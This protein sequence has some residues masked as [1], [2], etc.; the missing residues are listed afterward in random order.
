M[1]SQFIV[2]HMVVH[3]CVFIGIALLTIGH[4][5]SVSY[6]ISLYHYVI[7][8]I[9][10]DDG[11]NGSFSSIHITYVDTQVPGKTYIFCLCMVR[12]ESPSKRIYSMNEIWYEW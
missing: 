5:L 12:L 10:D 9:N 3:G 8:K 2:P 1:N 6:H 7:F 4:Q 11:T